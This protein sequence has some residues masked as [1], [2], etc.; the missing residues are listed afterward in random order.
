VVFHALGLLELLL[1]CNN[2]SVTLLGA[3][4][5]EAVDLGADLDGEAVEAILND[6]GCLVL[7]KMSDSS[8]M[9]MLCRYL[10]A[11]SCR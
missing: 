1:K 8:V 3:G 10:P 7:S 6:I 2:P 11:G 9:S 5:L 4:S